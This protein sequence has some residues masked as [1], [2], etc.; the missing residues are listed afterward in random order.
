MHKHTTYNYNVTILL[1]LLVNVTSFWMTFD[2]EL[3]VNFILDK[4]TEVNRKLETLLR[5]NNMNNSHTYVYTQVRLNNLETY[6]AYF[7]FYFF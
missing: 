2:F 7:C 5:T 4:K 3:H 1:I 6:Y